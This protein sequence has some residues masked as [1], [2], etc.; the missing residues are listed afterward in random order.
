[1]GLR[2]LNRYDKKE[3][4]MNCARLEKFEND[5][6][7]SKFLVVRESYWAGEAAF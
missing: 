5:P 4:H 7:T 2:N 3:D 6:Y 1:M